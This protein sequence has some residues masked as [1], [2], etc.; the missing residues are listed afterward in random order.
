[1]DCWSG[2]LGNHTYDKYKH[3]YLERDFEMHD[4]NVFRTLVDMNLSVR[5][6]RQEVLPCAVSPHE[7]EQP[8]EA[9]EVIAMAVCNEYQ[10]YPP[11][12][13]GGCALHGEL[14]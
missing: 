13:Y 6:S 7:A 1:M 3:H 4:W 12:P 14:G 9:K 2:K 11:W 5:I 10:G 8:R